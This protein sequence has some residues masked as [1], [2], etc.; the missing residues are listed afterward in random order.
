MSQPYSGQYRCPYCGTNS[1]PFIISKISSGG[2]VVFALMLLFCF[3]L[4]WIGLL[5]KDHHQIC[6]QCHVRLN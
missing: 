5:M 2:W 1:P 3:P 4:F 6:A